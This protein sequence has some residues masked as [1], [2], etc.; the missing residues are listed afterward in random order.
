[1]NFLCYKAREQIHKK[2]NVQQE[3]EN[4]END[5]QLFNFLEKQEFEIHLTE[6]SSF[7]ENYM[8]PQNKKKL[9]SNLKELQTTSVKVS[10]F[11]KDKLL[12]ELL[13]ERNLSLLRRYTRIKNSNVIKY[14][15]EPEILFGWAYNSKPFAKMYLKFQTKLTRTYTKILY[16]ICKD[17]ESLKIIKKELMELA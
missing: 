15:L 9:S 4:F 16:E 13:E 6:L 14:K 11:K 10:I 7:I 2:Y 12:Y 1:M 5:E 17:Y 8:L 3:I